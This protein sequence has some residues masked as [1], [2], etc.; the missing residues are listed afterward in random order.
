MHRHLDDGCFNVNK[1]FNSKKSAWK[2]E[3]VLIRRL[4]LLLKHKCFKLVFCFGTTFLCFAKMSSS[5]V[6]HLLPPIP[7]VF[8]VVDGSWELRILVTDLQ[9]KPE[10]PHVLY[11]CVFQSI[12]WITV[13]FG[14]NE[15]GYDEHLVIKIKDFSSRWS[16]TT[17]INIMNKSGRSRAVFIAEFELIYDTNVSFSRFHSIAKNGKAMCFQLTCKWKTRLV[18][19]S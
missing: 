17:R 2:S 1:K 3:T 15:L 13:K 8:P 19:K 9:V 18:I 10:L 14:Y 12:F 11:A 7:I 4:L 5:E 6:S 16:F